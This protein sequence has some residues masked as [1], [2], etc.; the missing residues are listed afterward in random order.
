MRRRRVLAALG[1][2]AVFAVLSAP[3]AASAQSDVV[4][5][6]IDSHQF[7]AVAL[8]VSINGLAPSDVGRIRLAENGQPV[9]ITSVRP[10]AEGGE[11]V[12][13]V[14][15]ID[16]SRSMVGE[17][18]QKAVAAAREFVT[19]SAPQIHIGVVMFAGKPRVVLPIGADRGKALAVL[20]TP[21]TTL[22]TSLYDAVA[23][24][25]HMFSGTGQRNIIVLSDGADTR[26][27]IDLA[28]AVA[29]SKSA[30]A[31]VFGVGL[32]DKGADPAALRSLAKDAGGRFVGASATELS[33]LYQDLASQ[34][35][36]QYTV[37]YRSHE[38]QGGQVS[39]TVSAPEG[40]DTS[41]AT[42]PR[43]SPVGP[44]SFPAPSEPLLHGPAGML[45]ALGLT[46]LAV[47]MV[48]GIG[49][50]TVI[51]DRHRRRLA[52][53]MSVRV[54]SEASVALDDENPL[55]SWIP[56]PVV[57]AGQKVAVA[58]GFSERLDARLERA[59]LPMRSGE[60]VIGS[61]VAALVMG[62][63]VGVLL[64]GWF[65][66]IGLVVGG[67]APAVALAMYCKRR[68]GK[69]QAQLPDVLMIIASSLRSGH[70]FLQALDMVSREISDPAAQEFSRVVAE[71]RLG[72]PMEEAMNSM[73]DRIG[74]DDYRWAFLAVNVQRDVGGNLAEVLDTVAETVRD[75]ETVRRQIDVLSA[76]GRLSG[77]VLIIMPIVIGL[78][79]FKVNR[80]YITLLF[81]TS[82]GWWM[83]GVACGL[84]VAGYLWMRKLVR[85][86]V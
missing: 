14:L 44:G 71:I 30:N 43:V 48:A 86:D 82:Q 8:T 77:R 32:M 34:L 69:L 45:I 61:V 2:L 39:L 58:G 6:G 21:Q 3:S 76:E 50:G 66:V 54:P 41:V 17:P 55:T 63:V 84:M 83:F 49:V 37:T 40:T 22:G 33:A 5:R 72:R 85:I 11:A 18:I 52:W 23:T 9:H 51:G 75:R 4:I 59:G 70:S 64:G 62:I 42:L 35:S 47:L 53:R 78:Y 1:F 25:S 67:A 12:E 60:F 65:G 28:A 56:E 10:L 29:A 15:V 7:P 19:K 38:T 68:V 46:F 13:V 31:A 27:R 36:Y 73:A 24:A 16:T 57:A 74:S 80:D 20:Q 79:M 81:T 26:S